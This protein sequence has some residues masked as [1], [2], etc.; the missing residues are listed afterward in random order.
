MANED[1]GLRTTQ[2]RK[3]GGKKLVVSH[4]TE[5][6]LKNPIYA[7]F[8]FTKDGERHELDE[9]IPRAISEETYWGIQKILGNKGRPRPSKNRKNFAYT[10]RTVCGGCGGSVTAEH[11]YQIICDCKLK[12]PLANR[13]HCPR[14][15]IAIEKM[16]NSKRLHYIYYH[17]TKT[18]KDTVCREG[19]VQELYIDETMASYYKENFSISRELHDWCIANLEASDARDEKQDSE[20]KKSLESSIA[21]KRGEYKELVIMKT[22]GLISDEDF[23]ELK[24]AQKAEIEALERVLG[25]RGVTDQMSVKRAI[26]AFDLALDGIDKIF[27]KGTVVEKK[28]LLSKIGSN[29]TIQDKKLNVYNTGVYEKIIN[30]LLRARAE[31][32]AFEPKNCGVYK[33]QT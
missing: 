26:R 3:Q 15:G 25:N 30:G 1:M 32:S 7:G 22:R 13:T 24:G 4:F 6:I 12:F 29:L 23:L 27:E 28:E 5:T 8:F 18:K 31:N 17:C 14:C 2:H 9:S 20:K 11:K 16:Q 10:G 19:S 21:K 33:G